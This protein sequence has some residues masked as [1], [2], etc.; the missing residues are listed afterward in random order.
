MTI[1][2]GVA[3]SICGFNYTWQSNFDNPDRVV[4][5]TCVFY[6]QRPGSDPGL[7]TSFSPW[8]HAYSTETKNCI[9]KIKVKLQ[10]QALNRSLSSR[11]QRQN[12]IFQ[13]PIGLAVGIWGSHTQFPGSTP[14]LGQLHFVTKRA[15]C[16]NGVKYYKIRNLHDSTYLLVHWIT[17]DIQ[18]LPSHMLKRLD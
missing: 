16:Q 12:F 10:F 14:A 11:E 15:T 13:I 9:E 3:V 18:P 7:A 8:R 1:P 2:D 17:L 4:V 5:R 6:Q